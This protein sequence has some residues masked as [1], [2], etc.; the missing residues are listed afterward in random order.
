MVSKCIVFYCDNTGPLPHGGMYKRAA[1]A[2]SWPSWQ[3]WPHEQAH[4]HPPPPQSLRLCGPGLGQLS[5][6][7]VREEQA[8]MGPG[9]HLALREGHAKPGRWSTMEKQAGSRVALPCAP[10][11][12]Q[13][14]CWAGPSC[15]DSWQGRLNLHL[16]RFSHRKVKSDEPRGH[17][18]LSGGSSNFKERKK[19]K[20][21]PTKP[22]LGPKSLRHHP[23][24]SRLTRVQ[25][26]ELVLPGFP[27][28]P[29]ALLQL[30]ML[31]NL[32]GLSGRKACPSPLSREAC[33]Q[34]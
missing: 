20:P 28:P 15:P 8:Q 32:S 14:G 19:L 2:P 25:V 31:F 1:H 22:I 4:C 3:V 16:Q 24:G 26:A 23:A 12:V 34:T 7:G 21:N 11:R 9:S 33:L 10:K 17:L 29:D 30:A 6:E 18:C 5:W 13:P 27:R